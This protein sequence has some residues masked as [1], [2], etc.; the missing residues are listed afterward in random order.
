MKTFIKYLTISIF[1]FFQ[2]Q[3]IQAQVFVGGDAAYFLT[4]IVN[5]NNYGFSELDYEFTGKTAFGFSIGY[6]GFNKHHVQ[7]GIKF[8]KLG[9]KYSSELD[10]L[11]HSRDVELNYIMIPLSYKMVFG[12]TELN[13]YATRAFFSIGGYVAIL[14]RAETT[15]TL[16]REEASLVDFHSSQS[17][18]GNILGIAQLANGS[19]LEDGKDQFESVDFGVTLS[20]GVRTFLTEGLALNLELLGG[21]GLGDMNAEEWRLNNSSGV[22]DASNNAFGGVQM[23]LHYYFGL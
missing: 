19:D 23:G 5:Q 9:Q 8:L 4:T 18:N 20:L 15:W 10:N 7:T 16:G 21:Y 2:N 11:T 12:D 1:L 6:A 17:R 3:N 13:S 22:Y 14:N